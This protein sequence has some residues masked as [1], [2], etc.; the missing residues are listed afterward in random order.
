MTVALQPLGRLKTVDAFQRALADL[1]V[2][3]P[4]DA[5]VIAGNASPLA[6]PVQPGGATM[7]NRFAIHPMEG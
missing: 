5:E 7:G 4:C 6:R 3:I 2:T 1:G